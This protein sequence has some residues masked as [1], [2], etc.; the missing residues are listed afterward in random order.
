MTQAATLIDR[1]PA[2]RTCTLFALTLILLGVTLTLPVG[3]L[4]FTSSGMGGWHAQ[5]AIAAGSSASLGSV[6]FVD[7]EHGWVVGSSYSDASSDYA[8]VILSTSDAG[9]T[10]NAKDAGTWRWRGVSG[11]ASTLCRASAESTIRRQETHSRARTQ[12]SSQEAQ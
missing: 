1:R 9:A 12:E 7:A 5:N 4:A 10:W 2:R 11:C 8:P 3:A 6:T